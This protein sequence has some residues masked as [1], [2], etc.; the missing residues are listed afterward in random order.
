MGRKIFVSYKYADDNVLALPGIPNTTVRNYVDFLQSLFDEYSD[1]INKG[2]SDGEDLSHLSEDTIWN[3]LKDRIYKSSTT[4][5][6]ISP[7]MREKSRTDRSQWIPWEVSFSLKETTRN[8]RTS[9]S[10]AMLAI[11]LPDKHGRYD[12]YFIK[13]RCGLI[14]H[15][16]YTLFEIIAKNMFNFNNPQKHY[17]AACGREHYHRPSSYIQA[18]KWEDFIRNPDYYIELAHERL[19]H[20]NDY[21]IVK[22]V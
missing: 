5:V 7:G 11:V 20:M 16:T 19:K 22:E 17:C 1:H 2:E 12:Y 15:K 14:L 18:V 9:H 21:N 13:L 3:K 6:M 4:I 10:N 8:D